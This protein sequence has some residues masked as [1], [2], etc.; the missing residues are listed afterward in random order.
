MQKNTT[1]SSI[2][3][4]IACSQEFSQRNPLYPVNKPVPIKSIKTHKTGWSQDSRIVFTLTDAVESI[5]SKPIEIEMFEESIA[6]NI[7]GMCAEF[8]DKAVVFINK[9]HNYC[10]SR[11]FAAKEMA[12]LL[13]N[14]ATKSLRT[15]DTA[16][17]NHT[18]NALLNLSLREESEFIKCEIDA[19]MGAVE[20]L[21]PKQSL[22]KFLSLQNSADQ[23]AESMKIPKRIVST[24]VSD[25]VTAKHNSIYSNP[26][27]AV[28]IIRERTARANP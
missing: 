9:K 7:D 22:D 4:C 17:I 28:A 15:T 14:H 10:W 27:Y 11:F 24:R 1:I 21:L 26:M 3:S 16:I 23:I 20:M 18:I 13:M 12:H 25:K 5:I 2:L 6:P 19:Y 8:E